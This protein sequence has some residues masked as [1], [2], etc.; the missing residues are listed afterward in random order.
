MNEN[1]LFAK[2]WFFDTIASLVATNTQGAKM[3]AQ[4]RADLAE[5]DKRIAELEAAAKPEPQ[6]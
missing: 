3:L 6:A 4:A 5:R 1:E 2:S